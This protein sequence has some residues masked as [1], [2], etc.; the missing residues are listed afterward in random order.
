MLLVKAHLVSANSCHTAQTDALKCSTPVAENETVCKKSHRDTTETAESLGCCRT[1][2]FM[3]RKLLRATMS[4][5]LND[6]AESS[7]N[8]IRARMSTSALRVNNRDV[9]TSIFTPSFRPIVCF[10]CNVVLSGKHSESK[11]QR[12]PKSQTMLLTGSINRLLVQP[13][14]SSNL[15]SAFF[16]FFPVLVFTSPEQ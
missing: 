9:H 16:F 12:L 6:C 1:L 5:K 10:V 8:G 2:L 11:Q 14:S 15:S 7:S 4:K 13:V 3:C